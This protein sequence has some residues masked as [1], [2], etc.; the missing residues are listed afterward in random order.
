MGGDRAAIPG[1]DWRRFFARK[2][3]AQSAASRPGI[4]AAGA[5]LRAGH[6]VGFR[7]PTVDA[8][9]RSGRAS[10][11]S[12]IGRCARAASSAVR[13]AGRPPPACNAVP[14]PV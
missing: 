11:R 3:Y 9:E 7:Y 13:P 6:A 14:R 12:A 5:V 2:P 8:G 10:G 4:G 1:A